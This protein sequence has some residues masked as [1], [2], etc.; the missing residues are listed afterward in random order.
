MNRHPMMGGRLPREGGAVGHQGA[1]FRKHAV[2]SENEEKVSV[3]GSKPWRREEKKGREMSCTSVT[4][5][6]MFCVKDFELYSIG[7]GKA[8]S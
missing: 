6:I 8:T 2:C 5:D 7:N 1:M 4:R 3:L